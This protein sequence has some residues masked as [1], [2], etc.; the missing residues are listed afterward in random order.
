M[1]RILN[2]S[3]ARPGGLSA[4]L[5]L[6]AQLA[7]LHEVGSIRVALCYFLTL[8]FAAGQLTVAAQ[9]PPPPKEELAAE[10]EAEADERTFR[11]AAL[12]T[13]EGTIGGSLREY[14]E[15]R[16]R[17]ARE[18]GAD[19]V[20]IEINS[21]GGE[22]EASL[23]IAEELADVDWA[24]TVAWIPNKALSGAALVSLGCDRIVMSPTARI[25]DA[26]IVFLDES[27]MFR[28][29][30][31]KVMS[32]LVRQARDLAERNGYPAEL[33]E[34]MIDRNAVVYER[35][36]EAGGERFRIEHFVA[37]DDSQVTAPKTLEEGQWVMI[38]ETAPSRFLDVNGNR[39]LELGLA[40][41][42]TDSRESLREQLAIEGE[43][44]VYR[45]TTTDTAVYWLNLPWVTGALFVIGLIALY[46]ELSA[47]GIS[48]GGLVSGLCFVLF[49]WSRFMGGTAAWLEVLL[50]VAGVIFLV[51]EIF[52]IPGTGISGVLGLLLIVGSLAMASQSFSIPT[53]TVEAGSLA[54]SVGV[55]LASGLIFVAIASLLSRYAGVIPVIRGFVLT[56]ERYEGGATPSLTAAGDGA[57]VSSVK[58]GGMTVSVGD[59]GVAESVLRPSGKVRFGQQTLDVVADGSYIEEGAAVE[60]KQ[61]QGN[62]LIVKEVP[63]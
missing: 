19:L 50:F 39:A 20:I 34:A 45:F 53:T 46:F 21:P 12:I 22:L 9:D 42:L 52:V 48:V 60:V 63:G 18:L 4:R 40:T 37:E 16:L 2:P 1:T 7:R 31:E 27:F 13:F 3:A 49:F 57:G 14:F 59:C 58:R 10:A 44:T 30:P 38:E 61:I 8:L 41:A 25:G 56:P 51:V 11:R 26:G 47:P 17:A 54:K 36:E 32:D 43:L 15:R 23:A 62:R 24:E 28:Y 55:L 35:A 6:I 33:A 5:G 29:A